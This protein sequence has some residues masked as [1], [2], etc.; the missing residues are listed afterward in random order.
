MSHQLLNWYITPYLPQVLAE[1]KQCHPVHRYLAGV[2]GDSGK[3]GGT[4]TMTQYYVA[5]SDKIKTSEHFKKK[6]KKCL[7]YF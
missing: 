3:G 7:H 6:R 2:A 5:L 1:T 4:L